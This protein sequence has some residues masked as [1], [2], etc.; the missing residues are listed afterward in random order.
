MLL[1]ETYYVY[2]LTNK[3]LT[4]LYTGVTNDL[5]HRVFQH[6]IKL[7]KGFTAKYNCDR[8]IYFE[9]FFDITEAIRR[10][11]QIK[12]YRRAWKENLINSQNP[13][14]RDLS[15]EWYDPREFTTFIR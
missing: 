4:V 5:V 3:N 9:E 15:S 13:E 12:R 8:L 7:N 11:K 2:I 14:W 6:K 1:T 10:E